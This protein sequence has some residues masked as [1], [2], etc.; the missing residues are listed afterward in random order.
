MFSKCPFCRA[1]IQA[2]HEIQ[3]DF[4]EIILALRSIEHFS[5]MIG[6]AGDLVRQMLGVFRPVHIPV[7]AVAPQNQ[8]PAQNVQPAQNQPQA[9]NAQPAQNQNIPANNPHQLADADRIR[10]CRQ[11]RQIMYDLVA[12]R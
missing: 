3:L 4:D 8:P 11:Y 10:R 2:V 9:Q 12:R 7:Q 6:G 1:P 5:N